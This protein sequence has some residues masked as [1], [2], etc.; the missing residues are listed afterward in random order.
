MNIRKHTI[1][2]GETLRTIAAHYYPHDR[3]GDLWA[4]IYRFNKHVIE[5]PNQLP[6]GVEIVIP[7]IVGHGD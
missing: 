1:R 2:R 5:D 7:H 6:I 3:R 4:V